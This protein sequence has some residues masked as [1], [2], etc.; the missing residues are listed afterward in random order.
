MRFGVASREL[1]MRGPSRN[2]RLTAMWW[3]PLWDKPG[4]S[5][6][7]SLSAVMPTT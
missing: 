7:K 5:D 4:P 2:E 1:V 3:P 6:A